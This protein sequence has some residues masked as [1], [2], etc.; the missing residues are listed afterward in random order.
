VVFIFE[1]Y[2]YLIF[3]I[4]GQKSKHFDVAPDDELIFESLLTKEEIAE[5]VAEN[6]SGSYIPL[7]SKN[8]TGQID[9]FLA[10]KC[11][12]KAKSKEGNFQSFSDVRVYG[13]L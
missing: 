13:L 7:R 6:C 2:I 12:G 9:D 8:P 5:K 4:S 11:G 1:N 3:S 10:D